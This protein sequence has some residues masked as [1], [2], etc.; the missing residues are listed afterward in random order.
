MNVEQRKKIIVLMINMFIA[1]GS[2]GIIIPI[3]PAYLE[4]INQGGTAAG[5][6][7]ALFAGAQLIFSPIAG[8]W[9][10][11][12]GRRKMIIYG[13]IG[14]TISMFVFYGFN[15][16]WWLY[17]SRVIGGI[18]AALLIPAIFAY[19]ADITTVGQRAKGNSLISAAMSLGIVIGP[20]IGGFLADFG[21]KMPLL[22]SALVS[23]VAVLFSIFILKESNTTESKDLPTDD[24]SMG[25][26]MVRSVKMPYFI[27]L[28]ITL[29]MSFGLMAYESVLG[30][31]VDNQFGAT[32]QEIAIMVTSTGIVS[33]IAQLFVVDRIVSRF[34]EVVVLNIF[35][36]VT[37]IGFLLSLFASSYILFFG[38]T[39]LIF[40]AT[41]ILRPVLN[42]LIS[43]MAGNEQGFAMGMNNAYMSI[44]NILGPT[45][46]GL[47]YDVNIIYPF[48]MGLIFLVLTMLVTIM[49]Q[50]RLDNK[51]KQIKLGEL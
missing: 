43:K 25:R 30:L 41:S 2:F 32:P 22:I 1:I 35:I 50:K 13:L 3:L 9:A 38:I 15:S 6:M 28:I 33:V 18:G 49:W 5:L 44:G 14:L 36:G 17:V 46:A 48:I 10:D 11:Q 31:F 24:E 21:L 37:T 34:G 7:I 4:S 23:L 20:G 40:L 16:I 12:Y 42:T 27:P 8:K 26:K 39:L 47:L 29:V 19:I 45:L 51:S